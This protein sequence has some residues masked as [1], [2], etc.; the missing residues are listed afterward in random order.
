M[1]VHAISLRIKLGEEH[2]KKKTLPL[3]FSVFDGNTPF[4]HLFISHLRMITITMP[5]FFLE[6]EVGIV[7]S[8]K[9]LYK[10]YNNY[11]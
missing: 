6:V 8:N 11:L 10:K 7:K 2:R 9:E 5:L 1:R 3:L 4:F